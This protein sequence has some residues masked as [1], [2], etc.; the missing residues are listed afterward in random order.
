MTMNWIWKTSV[1]CRDYLHHNEGGAGVVCMHEHYKAVVGVI[2]SPVVRR[3]RCGVT[4][5]VYWGLAQFQAAS[6]HNN[7]LVTMEH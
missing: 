7:F 4:S 3:T 2:E 6:I 1:D 5:G